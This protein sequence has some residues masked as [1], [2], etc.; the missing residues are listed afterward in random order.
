M[1]DVQDTAVAADED[2]ASGDV[3]RQ[4]FAAGEVVAVVEEGLD[5]VDLALVL[6]VLVQVRGDGGAD[7]LGRDGHGDH[8]LK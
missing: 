7:V 5:D 3:S 1:E 8:L 2:R 6:G 4:G